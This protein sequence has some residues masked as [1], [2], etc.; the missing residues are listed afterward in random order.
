MQ[1]RA[2][3]LEPGGFSQLR[4]S[5]GLAPDFPEK[6]AWHIEDSEEV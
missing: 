1:L 6:A 4:D 5:A 2:F 3:W